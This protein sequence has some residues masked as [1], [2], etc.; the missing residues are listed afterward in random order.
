MANPESLAAHTQVQPTKQK[1]CSQIM[2]F[3]LHRG[4]YG[5]TADELAFRVG[6]F[7]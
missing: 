3:A 6:V 2:A 7:P 1:I 4:L 5:F